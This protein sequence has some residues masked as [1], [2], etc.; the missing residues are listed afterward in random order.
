MFRSCQTKNAMK[1]F[2]LIGDPITHSQSPSLFREAFPEGDCT[3]DL[4]E[5]PHFEEAFQIFKEKYDG[6]NVTSPFKEEAYKA[7]ESA[8]PFCK[9]TGASN[10]LL[11]NSGLISAY[12]TDVVGVM[13]SIWN[14]VR[15]GNQ[16]GIWT[17]GTNCKGVVIGTGGAGAAATLALLNMGIDTYIT[18]RNR[19]RS[20]ELIERLS[21]YRSKL[22]INIPFS[23]IQ[24]ISAKC[25]IVIYTIPTAIEELKTFDFSNKIILEANYITPSIGN[26]MIKKATLYISGKEWLK[27]QAIASWKLFGLIR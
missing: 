24:K 19:T 17:T 4:I 25:E 23:E 15:I 26:N 16:K 14:G 20:I 6:I 1:K 7:A 2:G 12:N 13:H 8:S 5:T 3:Y 11:N 22:P 10:L 21:Q 9:M 18:N 27:Y